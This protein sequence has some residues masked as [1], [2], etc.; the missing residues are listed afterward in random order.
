MIQSLET[1]VGD[2][3]I[4]IAQRQL[5][6]GDRWRDVADALGANP[7]ESITGGKKFNL[8]TATNQA[9]NVLNSLG[10]D[11]TVIKTLSS[12]VSQINNVLSGDTAS[13]LT[14]IGKVTG[15]RNYGEAVKLVDW[16][17]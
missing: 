15:V 7:L 11:T 2:T 4:S 1:N 8:E 10:V 17:L 12:A 13:V 3:L 5:S 16:L 9:S 14:E 6:D